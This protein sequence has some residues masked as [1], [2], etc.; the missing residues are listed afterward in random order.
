MRE[1]CR[2]GRVP[3]HFSLDFAEKL[4]YE[5]EVSEG[6]GYQLSVVLSPIVTGLV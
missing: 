2:R 1:K 5:R 6:G 4:F 3:Y